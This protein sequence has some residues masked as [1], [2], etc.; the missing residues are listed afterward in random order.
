LPGSEAEFIVE[1]YWG[2]TKQRDGSTMEYQVEHP[3]W[4]VSAADL[5]RY[6]CDV[7]EIYG[8]EFAPFLR[9]PTSVFVADGSPVMV[10]RGRLISCGM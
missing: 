9:E 8:P 3:P 7:A 1:H 6:D 10:R 2:Y 4:N 5:V